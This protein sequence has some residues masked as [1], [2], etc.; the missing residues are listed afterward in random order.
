MSSPTGIHILL[1]ARRYVRPIPR[2]SKA[3]AREGKSENAFVRSMGLYVPS[4][5]ATSL[6]TSDKVTLTAERRPEGKMHVTSKGW[7]GEK[8]LAPDQVLEVRWVSGR[9]YAA[10]EDRHH[11]EWDRPVEAYDPCGPGVEVLDDVM[12]FQEPVTHHSDD[13]TEA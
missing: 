4:P 13:V 6:A 1:D 9:L 5:L 8:V 2:Q 7:D 10:R 3:A 11:D 12:G